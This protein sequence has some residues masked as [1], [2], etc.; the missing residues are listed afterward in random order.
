MIYQNRNKL[1]QHLSINTPSI[2]LKNLESG[3]LY[4]ALV[5]LAS[6]YNSRCDEENIVFILRAVGDLYESPESI[7]ADIKL[8]RIY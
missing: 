4:K 1:L 5:K 8:A 2:D 6:R 3:L 7:E